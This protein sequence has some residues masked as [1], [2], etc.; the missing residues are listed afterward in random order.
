VSAQLLRACD[1]ADVYPAAVW[2][3]SGSWWSTTA[4]KPPARLMQYLISVLQ[5]SKDYPNLVEQQ[6]GH[7]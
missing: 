1:M 4:L 3:L 7:T 6:G 2:W 5:V